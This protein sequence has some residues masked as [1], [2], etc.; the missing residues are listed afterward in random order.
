MKKL[1]S[2]NIFS[3]YLSDENQPYGGAREGDNRVYANRGSYSIGAGS[4][5]YHSDSAWPANDSTV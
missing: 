1:N 4:D 3:G 5:D 2:P